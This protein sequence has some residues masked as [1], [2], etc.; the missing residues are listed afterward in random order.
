M[1]TTTD[2]AIDL[3]GARIAQPAVVVPGAMA[4]LQALGAAIGDAGIAPR[5]VGLVNMR[6]SQI[7][8]CAVCLEGGIRDA[9]RAGETDDRLVLLA[10]WRETPSFTAAER[11]AIALTEAVT[12]AAD[13]DDAV[14][15]A[16]WEDAARHY[17]APQLAALVLQIANI[18]LWNRL[19]VAT[20]QHAG[21]HRW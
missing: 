18:N 1:S 4:A 5:T 20:R 17:D 11:A 13:R 14:S 3:H 12:R 16:V 19:N 7:N 9:R 2:P 21:V 6:A 8:G 10:A 15:D